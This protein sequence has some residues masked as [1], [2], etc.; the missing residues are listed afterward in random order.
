M[1]AACPDKMTIWRAGDGVVQ[2]PA[3]VS[4]GAFD[5][6]MLLSSRADG[7]MTAMRAFVPPGVLTHWHSH[8]RGQLLHVLDGVGLVQR[9]GGDI[10]E[11]RSGDSI[12][13]APDEKHWHGAAPT[14]PFSYLSVQPVK[15]GTAAHWMNPVQGIKP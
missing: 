3:G 7:E 9:D 11:V 14:S 12:W 8:P 4:S 2:A 5:V 10:V 15:D 6:Q 1:G 13:F